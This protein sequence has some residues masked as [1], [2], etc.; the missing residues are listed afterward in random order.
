MEIVEGVVRAVRLRENGNRQKLAFFWP[1]ALLRHTRVLSQCYTAEAVT[2]CCLRRPHS[3]PPNIIPTDECGAEQILQELLPLLLAISKKNTTARLAWFPL[4]IRQHLPYDKR[5]AAHR[6]V[7]PRANL[8]D[9][10]GTSTEMVCRT[11]AEFRQHALI[12][13]PSRKSIGFSTSRA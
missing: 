2:T 8:A 1:G 5:R 3:A 7:L 6:I 12:D 10:L 13:L 4:R 11:L 9:H